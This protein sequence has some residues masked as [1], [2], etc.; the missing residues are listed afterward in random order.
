MWKRGRT[1]HHLYTW[2]SYQQGLLRSFA[3]WRTTP[4]ADTYPGGKYCRPATGRESDGRY[5][6]RGGRQCLTCTD[7]GRQ[8]RVVKADET[9]IATPLSCFDSQRRSRSPPVNSNQQDWYCSIWRHDARDGWLPA[10]RPH[11]TQRNIQP[12]AYHSSDS[13]DNRRWP[14]KG[15]INGCR[16][17][18]HQAL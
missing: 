11:Q 8:H 7:C 3:D 16:W 6:T 1:R 4:V 18:Y 17:I 10:N 13:Q 9:A 12:P 14:A 15:P 2:N 5:S